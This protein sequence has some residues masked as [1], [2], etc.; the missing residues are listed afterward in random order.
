MEYNSKSCLQ[1]IPQEVSS[2]TLFIY[3]END[4]KCSLIHYSNGSIDLHCQTGE[5]HVENIKR[6]QKILQDK[7]LRLALEK[8]CTVGSSG[9]YY[10]VAKE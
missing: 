2:E 9:A 10:I 6:A 3:G 1:I 8:G 4:S 7:G 5:E